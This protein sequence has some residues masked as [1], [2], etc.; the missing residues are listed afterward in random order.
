MSTPIGVAF[1]FPGEQINTNSYYINYIVRQINQT[2]HNNLRSIN[3]ELYDYFNMHR[4]YL[5]Y[6]LIDYRLENNNDW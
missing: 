6:V 4:F 2:I 3:T 5:E 1:I